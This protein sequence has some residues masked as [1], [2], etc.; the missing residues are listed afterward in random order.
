MAQASHKKPGVLARAIVVQRRRDAGL[1][2]GKRCRLID[3][4]MR[5]AGERGCI[6]TGLLQHAR[7]DG[8]MALLAAVRGAGQR[9]LLIAKTETIR[10]AGFDKDKRLQG[11]DGGAWKHRRGHVA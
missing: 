8:D 9:Q 7:S 11:L 10:R 2:E 3:R 5:A 4:P 6:E 1:G